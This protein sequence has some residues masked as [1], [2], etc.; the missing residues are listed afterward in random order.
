M[1]LLG[2]E[3]MQRYLLGICMLL[4]IKHLQLAVLG[5]IEFCIPYALLFCHLLEHLQSSLARSA[6][7]IAVPFAEIKSDMVRTARDAQ[8]T[9]KVLKARPMTGWVTRLV[10]RG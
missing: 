7:R 4:L 5:S 10:G 9:V 3:C 2:K 6:C 1:I 8:E